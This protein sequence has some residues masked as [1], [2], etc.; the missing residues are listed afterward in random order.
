MYGLEVWGGGV[1]NLGKNK[2]FLMKVEV[3]FVEF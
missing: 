3:L 2:G 1:G